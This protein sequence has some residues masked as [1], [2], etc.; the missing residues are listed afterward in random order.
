MQLVAH[1]FIHDFVWRNESYNI[2]FYDFP[3]TAGSS[4]KSFPVS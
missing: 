2:F 1:Y 4:S 3:V